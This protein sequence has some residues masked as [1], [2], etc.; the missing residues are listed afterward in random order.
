MTFSVLSVTIKDE[1]KRLKKDYSSY[2]VYSIDEND[3]FVKQCIEETLGNFD[4]EP[5]DI[6]YNIKVQVQ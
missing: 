1:E 4:G 2:E 5:S 3:P 6:W